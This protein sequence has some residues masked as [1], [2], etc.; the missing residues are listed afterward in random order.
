MKTKIG[1]LKG[2]IKNKRVHEIMTEQRCSRV[3]AYK[4][5][6]REQDRGRRKAS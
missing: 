5:L 1:R 4:L 3:W 2:T 6:R